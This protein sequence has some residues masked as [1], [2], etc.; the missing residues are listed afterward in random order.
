MGQE[1]LKSAREMA[2]ITAECLQIKAED[3]VVASTGVI[4]V[5][6]PMELISAGIKDASKVLSFDG[7]SD[8]AEAIMTTDLA[9]RRLPASSKL[10]GKP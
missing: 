10:V 1:G 9:K 7:G 4:G 6:L 3:V 5:P 2:N 8:A